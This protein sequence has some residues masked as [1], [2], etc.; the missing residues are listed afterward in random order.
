MPLL[1]LL[2]RRLL[3]VPL[4][5]MRRLLRRGLLLMR[6]RRLRRPNGRRQR[7]R[8]HRQPARRLLPLQRV[9]LEVRAWVGFGKRFSGRGAAA[10]QGSFHARHF[11]N[12]ICNATLL[13]TAAACVIFSITP[14][15]TR[16]LNIV[17]FSGKQI[18]IARSSSN[19]VPLAAAAVLSA[20]SLLPLNCSICFS[21]RLVIHMTTLFSAV[22]YLAGHD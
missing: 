18:G 21:I 16:K 2:A 8:R 4:Q 6:R 1:R 13:L 7:R 14:K 22:G 20:S 15:C 12:T 9:P 17:R 11:H 10:V 3:V 19:A 5:L